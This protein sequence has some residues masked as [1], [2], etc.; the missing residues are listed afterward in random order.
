M[1]RPGGKAALTVD[2]PKPDAATGPDPPSGRK[3]QK[4]FK[5]EEVGGRRLGGVGSCLNVLIHTHSAMRA[6]YLLR[7]FALGRRLWTRYA[8][9]GRRWKNGLVWPGS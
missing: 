5:A 1:T 8:L 6:V 3:R 4:T 7:G 9:L 2:I